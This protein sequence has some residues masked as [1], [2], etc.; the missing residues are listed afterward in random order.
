MTITEDSVKVA[1]KRMN[2]LM[3]KM[4]QEFPFWAFLIEKCR[5]HL[6]PESNQKIPTACI[7]EKGDIYINQ[8]FMQESSDDMMHFVLAHEVMHMLLGHF[9]RVGARDP[10]MWNVAGDV[11]INNMLE[12]HFQ[13][14]G[15]SI[16]LSKYCTGDKFGIFNSESFTTEQ[17]YDQVMQQAKEAAKQAKV[18]YEKTGQDM[19]NSSDLNEGEALEHSECIRENSESTPETEKSWAEAGLESATRAR[20]AGNCPGFMERMVDKINSTKVPWN[21][22]LAYYLRQRFCYNSKHRHTFTPPN[23]RYLYQDIVLTSRTGAKKP[24]LAFCIDT[25]G[26]MSQEDISVG[27]AEMNNIRKLYKVPL[28]LI[29]CD[30]QVHK[31][32]WIQPFEDLPSLTGGGG[33][34]FVPVM[35]HI[36]SKNIDIDV[37]VFFTDGYGDFG[38]PP[39]FDVIW[40]MNSSA[41]APY[42]KV[43][44]I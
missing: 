8:K 1:K 23:R 15:I 16:D 37:L 2:K 20:M 12:G 11:L 35:D 36:I 42:G 29:E 21:E 4:Y 31:A 33:T 44:R 39:P 41:S 6:V 40:T 43:I 30:Y 5:L 18:I 34:S 17:V 13:Q 3:F 9:E 10:F 14:K 28:Y 7:T 22:V 38:K 26:S 24:S 19:N 25:S 27:I 32:A